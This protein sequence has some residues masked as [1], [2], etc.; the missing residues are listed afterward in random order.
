MQSAAQAAGAAPP[1]PGPSSPADDGLQR[2]PHALVAYLHDQPL[3]TCIY[4]HDAL[5]EDGELPQPVWQNPALFSFLN[6]G[7]GGAA[8]LPRSRLQEPHATSHDE[9]HHGRT[10]LSLT[11]ALDDRSKELLRRWLR[12]GI[13]RAMEPLSAGVV[14]SPG[15]HNGPLKVF[16]PSTTSQPVRPGFGGR[17]SSSSSTTSTYSRQSRF[18]AHRQI[19]L[20]LV[21]GVN[22]SKVH[23]RATVVLDAG[24]TVLT[25]L[26]ASSVANGGVFTEEDE[27]EEDEDD[28]VEFGEEARAR[29]AGDEGEIPPEAN[30]ETVDN[31]DERGAAGS[32]ARSE[33]ERMPMSVQLA[34][35]RLGKGVLVEQLGEHEISIE[36][37]KDAVSLE[38]LA[39]TAWHAPI[40]LFRVNRD[41]SITQANPKWRQTCGLAEGETNDAWPARIHPDDRERVVQHYQRITRDLP[42]ERDECEF[43][44]VREGVRDQWCV[45]IIEPAVIN[46]RLDGYCGQLLNINKHKAAATASE[47]REAQLRNELAMLGETAL[48]GLARIDLDGH[49]ISANDSWYQIVNLEKGRPLDEWVNELHPDDS[50]WVFEKWHRCLATLDPFQARFRWKYGGV[51]LAQARPNASNPQ[52][53][54]GWLASVTNVTAQTRAEEE[55]LRISREREEAAQRY[56]DEAEERRKVAVEEKRQQE[57]LIDVT[58]HEIRNPISAILQNADFTRSSLISLRDRLAALEGAGKFPQ[59]LDSKLLDTLDE[60]IEALDAIA[61]CGMAQ[62]RIAND[63]LGLAQIQLSKYSITPIEFELA[64]SLR[65]ICRM[66]KAGRPVS[67][68][69]SR[70]LCGPTARLTQVLV[71]LLSNAIRFTAKS[72]TRIVTLTVEVSARP[73]ERDT[74]LIPPPE[75]EYYIDKQK[76]VYLFFS[77]EDT[78]PGMTEEETSRLFAKFMQAS[79]F[80]H[81]TW[82]GSGL[83][84]WIA[85]NLCELQAGRIEVASTVGKGSIFRCFITARSVDAGLPTHE[86]P[87]AVVEG[88]TAPNAER[89]R[90]PAVFLSRSGDDAS[91]LKGLTILCCEDNQI[92]RTVLRR[93]LVKEGCEDVLL[94]C[95]G[96]E[97]LELLASRPSGSIDCI[98]MDIE[99][100]VMDGL[101][102][103]RAI[104]LMEQQGQRTGRQRIVG[105][106]GNARNA[107]KEAALAAGMNCVVTKPYKVPDLIARIRADTPD[108]APTHPEHTS[109]P[110]AA[111]E[112]T[113]VAA[114]PNDELSQNLTTGATVEIIAPGSP[115]SSSSSLP[116]SS[117]PT[118]LGDIPGAAQ[119]P[120]NPTLPPQQLM[121]AANSMNHHGAG[122]TL[123]PSHPE[124]RSLLK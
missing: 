104:R 33:P 105:L 41:L 3:S 16:Q 92:N 11:D 31:D 54:S 109:A 110:G 120:Q 80:T 44:W 96:K 68:F 13:E 60:D 85:R 1:P 95:D 121:H 52:E 37:A 102:A 91:P 4:S 117:S 28:I 101:E 18:Q 94:A 72:E 106:T 49:F 122:T 57:L 100:P 34:R 21:A 118:P 12:D 113:F 111:A 61:E 9:Q 10:R 26:P 79:P 59:D 107:Q 112:G 39:Y 87:V 58:S 99:M 81:T 22:F 51:C 69:V 64:T 35:Q 20:H 40:G 30:G 62:E 50:D 77:V 76:P 36:G 48:V 45:C 56:A 47:L 24:C 98:L 65:N 90:A 71:N 74:P 38:G 53:A 2:L 42:F 43:R 32:V 63:I 97:G 89:G 93:Q 108:I 7:V 116:F 82:G 70:S 88:I 83:G 115:T 84:L 78:G 73:P 124:G 119:L 66:F 19:A 123:P 15:T 23:W 17:P 25:M 86:R 8:P 114:Q 27:A 67:Y 55:L 46:G 6:Q 14:P 5:A 29:A 103:S 75:T